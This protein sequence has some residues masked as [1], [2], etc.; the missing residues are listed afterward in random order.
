MAKKEYNYRTTIREALPRS[1]RRQLIGAQNVAGGGASIGAGAV[2]GVEGDGHTHGNKP[3][4]DAQNIDELGYLWLRRQTATGDSVTEK[5]RSG[6]ADEAAHAIEATHA[7]HSDEAAHAAEADEATHAAWADE[8]THAS[9]AD[10]SGLWQGHSWDDWMDQAVRK[11]DSVEHVEV[12]TGS[13]RSL[14]QWTDGLLGNGYRLWEDKSGVSHLTIDKLTVRQ[15]MVVLEL[16]I[17]KIRSVGGQ[18]VVSA[19]NGKIK[20]VEEEGDFY[21]L[22]M[23]EESGFQAHDL[24]RC[25][26]WGEGRLRGYWVE[27]K[28]SVGKAVKVAQIEFKA[29][30]TKPMVGDECVLMGNKVDKSRQNLVLISATEDGKPRVDVLNGVSGC[31]FDGC[32][33]ARL[34]NLDGIK[35]NYFGDEQPSGDGLYGDNVWLRGRFVLRNGEDVETRFEVTDGK[36]SSAVAGV[37]EDMVTGNM[38]RNGSFTEGLAWWRREVIAR[39]YLQSEDKWVTS[40]GLLLTQSAQGV[41]VMNDQGRTVLHVV[42]GRVRQVNVDMKRKPECED[43]KAASVKLTLTYKC[44]ESGW[45]RVGLTGLDKQ[46]YGDFDELWWE[47]TVAVTDGYE[48]MSCVGLWNGTGDFVLEMA[49]DIYVTNVVLTED[50]AGEMERQYGTL[51]EQDA[52]MWTVLAANFDDA[53]NVLGGS[54]I[55]TTAEGISLKTQ[56]DITDG[57]SATGI[58]IENKK[59]TLTA[60]TVQVKNNMG[61]TTMLL[62]NEGKLTADLLR[63]SR[64][65]MAG[66]EGGLR[67]EI[68]ADNKSVEIYDANGE[69]CT[70]FEGNRFNGIDSI[71]GDN[72]EDVNVTINPAGGSRELNNYESHEDSIWTG[73]VSIGEWDT[74][75]PAVVDFTGGELVTN[76]ISE[77]NDKYGPGSA[78]AALRLV[79]VT[80]DTADERVLQ[81]VTVAE[82]SCRI[83]GDGVQVLTAS[84][85]K[86]LSGK[87]VKVVAGHHLLQLRYEMAATNYG[88]DGCTDRASTSWREIAANYKTEFYISRYFANGYVIGTRRDNYVQAINTEAGMSFAVESGKGGL[89][90]TPD[91]GVEIKGSDGN[92]KALT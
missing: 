19:A 85:R 3:V 73:Y 12:C 24:I 49:G 84:D 35:D 4:L 54:S 30:G 89:R 41:G 31:S 79:V 75:T 55:A 52:K 42:G 28:E 36:I 26:V 71:W 69:L 61:Q 44:L 82:S 81:T 50:T 87:R 21:V 78:Q 7:A 72:T 27:V 80:K 59:I 53:G 33:R 11:G 65:L 15:T 10:D 56:K 45:L 92:W 18:I 48:E 57:L 20:S 60:D 46:G 37:R 32:L 51:V 83:I 8:A 74:D 23:E 91:N 13:V 22:K 25:Q 17:E 2:V 88:A 47:D 90:I 76:A 66:D 29:Y 43:N 40:E 62:D 64:A 63:A 1:K 77:E 38:L 5:V 58:D 34:G 14:G 70:V 67:V 6:Y 39:E 16:L 9:M 68:T 86:L